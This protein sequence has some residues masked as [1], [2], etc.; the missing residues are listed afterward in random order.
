LTYAVRHRTALK[1]SEPVGPSYNEVRMHPRGRGTQR[2]LA[3]SL[4]TWPMAMP[5]SRIDY[6]GNVAYR[7]DIRGAHDRLELVVD[8][9]IQSS[10]RAERPPPAWT[11]EMVARDPRLEFAL[12]S[13]RVAI[14]GAPEAIWREWTGGDRGSEALL[15]CAARMPHEFRYLAGI[16][17]VDSSIDEFLAVGSG[18]CQDFTHLFIAMARSAGWPAR[19]V[20]GYLGPTGNEATAHGASHAWAEICG[21]DGHWVG[22]DPTHGGPTGPHHL[23]LAVGRDYDDVAPHRGLFYG[24]A[25]AEPAEVD[26]DVSRLQPHA[27]QSIDIADQG[28]WR[29]QQEQQ[30]Q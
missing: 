11:D 8:A 28:T 27:A 30:Q 18:V 29:S 9:T 13:P 17:T 26:V 7:V 6:Y 15:S 24:S 3:F 25:H 10:P 16:T 12:P 14:G 21:S 2:L 4:T 5:R 20:S 22:V 19:Y 23:T 1:Y